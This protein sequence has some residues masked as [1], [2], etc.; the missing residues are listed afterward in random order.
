MIIQKNKAPIWTYY[1]AR[2][3]SA[4]R[5]EIVMRVYFSEFYRKHFKANLK[6]C[7]VMPSEGGNHAI[8]YNIE[9]WNKFAGKVYQRSCK[10]LKTFNFYVGLIKQTQLKSLRIAQNIISQPLQKLSWLELGQQWRKWDE[11]HLQHFLKPIWIPFIVEPLLSVDAKN[12]LENLENKNGRQTKLQED[13]EIVFGP[14]KSNAISQE[15]Y[16][17][18]KM[19]LNIK[20][21]KLKGSRLSEAC[22]K[23]ADKF[24]FIPCYDVIDT[25]WDG[26]YFYK[27][28]RLL[29]KES[30]SSLQVEIKKFEQVYKNRVKAFKKLLVALKPN[31]YQ[32]EL[33]QMAHDLTF[34]KDER[35]D[36]RRRQSF[37]IRPLFAELARRFNLPPRAPLYL[38]KSEMEQWF[39][40]GKLPVNKKEL[41]Q[42]MKGYCLVIN[43]GSSVSIYSG[44]KMRQ[45]IKSQKFTGQGSESAKITGLVGNSGVVKGRVCVVYTKHDLKKIKKDSVL[46]AVTTNPDYVPA[47]RLCKAFVTDEGGVTCHAAIVAREMKKPCIIGTK[48]ATKVFKDGDLVEVDAD[49]GVVKRL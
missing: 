11:A 19:A 42:R 38:I 23:H 34:I 49:K 45:F 12:I 10:N 8:C 9:E 29:S 44:V 14:D 6:S 20:S 40:T 13:F 4:S 28:V 35:D 24:G 22:K 21:G 16:E 33:L 26:E 15:R 36:Y 48:V 2:K 47:M 5:F 37:T 25:P 18:L 43:N 41:L 27:Q 46:V 31:K 3:F 39:K 7:L 17:L 30:R 1:F 32:K